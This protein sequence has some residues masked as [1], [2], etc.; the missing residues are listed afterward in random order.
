[1]HDGK[2]IVAGDD[3]SFVDMHFEPWIKQY[4]YAGL[5]LSQYPKVKTWLSTVQAVPEL[6]RASEKVESG[7]KA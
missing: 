6:V 3:F 1:M 2:W 7:E 5:I 4:D